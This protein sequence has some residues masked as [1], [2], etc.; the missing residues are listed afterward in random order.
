PPSPP[1][2]RNAV[3]RSPGCKRMP[4]ADTARPFS[5]SGSSLLTRA[6]YIRHTLWVTRYDPQEQYAAGD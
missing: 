1:S 6:G 2:R 3:G 5:Y 4:G